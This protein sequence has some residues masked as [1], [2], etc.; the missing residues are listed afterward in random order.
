MA[1]LESEHSAA[2]DDLRKRHSKELKQLEA[3]KAQDVQLITAK[4]DAEREAAHAKLQLE[5]GHNHR[6]ASRQKRMQFVSCAQVSIPPGKG[7]PRSRRA[8]FSIGN[9]VSY[10][11]KTS[12]SSFALSSHFVAAIL[13]REVA[14]GTS[15]VDGSLRHAGGFSKISSIPKVAATDLEERMQHRLALQTAKMQ[16][17]VEQF[18]TNLTKAPSSM[19]DVMNEIGALC[20]Y[21]QD[22]IQEQT[23]A[24]NQMAGDFQQQLATMARTFRHNLSEMDRQ[25]RL[26]VQQNQSMLPAPGQTWYAP[27]EP[28]RVRR[29]KEASDDE[30]GENADIERR[31]RTW[32]T[33]KRKK[34]AV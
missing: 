20:R 11:R 13:P 12:G 26:A 1:A 2:V 22:L 10:A 24:M 17:V 8:R 29:R 7:T 25:Y 32:K 14:Y 3:Q 27:A 19:H 4:L 6:K 21:Y 33:V 31:V 34:A 15:V 30:Y 16:R 9:L 28:T 18:D 5:R 23:H